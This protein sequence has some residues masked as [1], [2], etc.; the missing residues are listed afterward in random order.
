VP[1]H[2]SPSVIVPPVSMSTVYMGLP[3]TDAPLC[4][5]RGSVARVAVRLHV[6]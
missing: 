2:T 5:L 1:S 4:C 3:S 6:P